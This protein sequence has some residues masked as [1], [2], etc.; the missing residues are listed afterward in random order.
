M[1]SPDYHTFQLLNPKYLLGGGYDKGL[2]AVPLNMATV[3]QLSLLRRIS[4]DV[5]GTLSFAKNMVQGWHLQTKY[6]GDKEG[7]YYK[8]EK[9]EDLVNEQFMMLPQNALADKLTFGFTVTHLVHYPLERRKKSEEGLDPSESK[10]SKK[11]LNIEDQNN[12]QYW[13]P[14]V[15]EPSKYDVVLFYNTKTDARFYKAY[16]RNT[17]GIRDQD[18]EEIPH[19]RV[20]VWFH[21]DPDTG[22]INSPLVNAFS[23]ISSLEECITLTL[24]AQ[25]KMALPLTNYQKDKEAVAMSD[26]QINPQHLMATDLYNEETISHARIQQQQIAKLNIHNLTNEAMNKDI[27]SEVNSIDLLRQAELRNPMHSN[28]ASFVQMMRSMPHVPTMKMPIGVTA[29]D[30]PKA[31]PLQN[32]LEFQTSLRHSLAYCFGVPFNIISSTGSKFAADTAMSKWLTESVVK[33]WHLMITQVI[34]RNFIDIYYWYI[35]NKLKKTIGRQLSRAIQNQKLSESDVEVKRRKMVI[36]ERAYRQIAKTLQF[37]VFFER[38]SLQTPEYIVMLY[39]YGVIDFKEFQ[40]HMLNIGGLPQSS[41]HP[42]SKPPPTK[43]QLEQQRMELDEKIAKKRATGGADSASK[44]VKLNDGTGNGLGKS[45]QTAEK[46][47][48]Q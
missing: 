30:G 6:Q 46:K 13:K 5:A 28:R 2:K 15:L 41:R 36:S 39:D 44:K 40:T 47:L 37:T 20:F 24:T 35:K 26:Q 14:E 43:F 21:P 11:Q 16:K 10:K 25:D 33:T 48:N 27:D 42:T 8:D 18:K 29:V 32:Y 31:A 22:A 12:P 38:I 7:R 17:I 9:T 1:H 19:S 4:P 45:L 34:I 23:T 3:R